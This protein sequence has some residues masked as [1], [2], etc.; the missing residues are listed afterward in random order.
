DEINRVA[1]QFA[2]IERLE[3]MPD[4]TV[5]RQLAAAARFFV[6]RR[7]KD[8]KVP[9]MV[10]Y[11]THD[12]FVPNVHSRMLFHLLPQARLVA[13]EGAGHELTID[14]GEELLGYLK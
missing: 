1:E 12:R 9:T 8:L 14:K 2:E 13:I 11:G 6:K 4:K 7:L 10:V 5:L 3:G